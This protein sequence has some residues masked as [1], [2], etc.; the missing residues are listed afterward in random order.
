MHRDPVHA[1]LGKIRYEL[2]RVIDHQM[3]IERERSCPAQGFNHGGTDCEVRH[4]VPIHDIDV[5]NAGTTRRCALNLIGQ[6]SEVG[7]ED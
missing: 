3:A 5:N 6:V 4:K 1:C 7:G 2:V